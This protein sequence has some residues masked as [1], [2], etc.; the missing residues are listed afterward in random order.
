MQVM[1]PL[2]AG[3]RLRRA[4]FDND[5]EVAITFDVVDTAFTA[6]RRA[7]HRTLAELGTSLW[8]LVPDGSS[9]ALIAVVPRGPCAEFKR[10][11]VGTSVPQSVFGED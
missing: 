11:N 5:L 2:F 6:V 9:A 1:T 8:L 7:P 3:G 4:T 10:V